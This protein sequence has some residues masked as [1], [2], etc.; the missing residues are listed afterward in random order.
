MKTDGFRRF[1]Y[2]VGRIAIHAPPTIMA[3]LLRSPHKLAGVI[4]FGQ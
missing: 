4:E 3:R 2:W 1:L